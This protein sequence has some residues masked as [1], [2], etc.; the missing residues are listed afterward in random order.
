MKRIIILFLISGTLSL[1]IAQDKLDFSAQIRPRL[2]LDNRDFNSSTGINSFAEMRTRAAIKFTPN[3]EITGFIQIQDSRLFGSEPSTISNTQN[4][5][6]HQAYFQVNSLFDLPVNFKAGRMHAS[7]GTQR[8]M[9]ANNWNNIGRS[10]DGAV[11]QFDLVEDI[12]TKLDLF[13]FRVGE[14]GLPGDSSDENVF[15]AFADMSFIE[16][17]QFQPFLIYRSSKSN[18]YP[19][20][21]FA[22]GSYLT[23]S[24]SGFYHQAEFIYQ[25]GDERNDGPKTLSAY[26]IGYNAGYRFGC[27]TKPFISAGVDYYSGDDD[28][29]DNKYK[30]F[31][32][33]FGAGHG[34][35]GYMDYFPN[36]TFGV[37]LMDI[38]LR[39]GFRPIEKLRIKSAFHVFNSAADYQLPNNSTTN[40]FG[41]EVDLVATYDYND[42][43]DLEIGG[44]LFLPGGIFKDKFGNDNSTWFYF[45][46]IVDL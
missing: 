28:L 24:I 9:S 34:Y 3:K 39:A 26:F 6:I 14:S 17:H 2:I 12:K 30:E 11:I 23:G 18:A 8:I 43:L 38:H 22:A 13:A 4:V 29:T 36:N 5:D 32:R 21:A 45:M 25:F 20:N 1:I 15:G 31:D 7:Y 46:G 44:G 16:G 37:G 42:Y 33:W 10:F 41:T 19:F 35:L 40:K 27:E